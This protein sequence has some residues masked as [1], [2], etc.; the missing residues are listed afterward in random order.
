M[1]GIIIQG[2]VGGNS[3]N[4]SA[5]LLQGAGTAPQGST[6]S[7]TRILQPTAAIPANTV[8]A[9]PAAAVSAS[10]PSYDPAAAAAAAKAAQINQLKGSITGLVKNIHS[11]YDAIFGQAT[12]QAADKVGQINENFGQQEDQL[13]KGYNTD[14]ATSGNNYAARGASDSSYRMDNQRQITDQFNSGQDQLDQEKQGDIAGVGSALASTEGGIN[15]DETS[16]Q[17]ILD[18]VNSS[19]DADE[20]NTVLGTVQ[21][22]LNQLNGGR[23][24]YDTTAQSIAAAPVASNNLSSLESSLQNIVAG[25]APPALKLSVGTKL[26]QTAGLPS[27][28]EAA[29]ISNLQTQLSGTGDSTD[30]NKQQGQ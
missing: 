9:K 28:Q 4:G 30:P 16:M 18:R 17:Q 12:A 29:A 19:T 23:S 25:S 5:N 6:G 27:D 1:A 3:G 15:A 2:A 11:V 7:A 24:Q 10:T 21:D 20:L 26:I 13:T 14:E 8:V 22:K